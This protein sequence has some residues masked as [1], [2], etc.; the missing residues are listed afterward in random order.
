MRRLV[1]VWA[2][3]ALGSSV[4]A[5][6]V[7]VKFASVGAKSMTRVRRIDIEPSYIQNLIVR[8]WARPDAQLVATKTA[9]DKLALTV[10]RVEV[11]VAGDTMSIRLGERVNGAWEPLRPGSRIDLVIDAPARL[12]GTPP[13][14]RQPGEPPVAGAVAIR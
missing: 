4:H 5:E 13:K 6:E 11:T 8:P 2:A 14:R 10:M 1:V 12:T 3:L 7:E 9:T